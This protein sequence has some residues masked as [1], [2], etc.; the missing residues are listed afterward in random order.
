MPE[1]KD[2]TARGER[3]ALWQNRIAKSADSGPW[4]RHLLD[5]DLGAGF[6][7]LLLDLGGL[8]LRDAFLDRLGRALDEILG[9]LEADA[10]HFADHLDR[11]DLVAARVGQDDREL[12]L[13][14]SR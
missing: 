12:G 13:L 2:D 4:G 5:V 9:F 6:F 1:R 11:V 8:V 14:F 10:G 7:E 3:P